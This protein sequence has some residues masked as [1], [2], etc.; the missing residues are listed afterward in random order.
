MRIM[1]AWLLALLWYARPDDG[2]GDVDDGGNI[3]EP[4]NEKLLLLFR[5]DDGDII[6]PATEPPEP[7]PTTLPPLPLPP[8]ATAATPR[9]ID[10]WRRDTCCPRETRRAGDSA[11]IVE[12]TD[13]TDMPESGSTTMEGVGVDGGGLGDVGGR[14]VEPRRVRIFLGLLLLLLLLL[15]VDAIDPGAPDICET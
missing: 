11:D 10:D 6:M 5:R 8:E 4:E 9:L 14:I 2:A 15:F 7:F 12:P 13:T 1:P 3:I